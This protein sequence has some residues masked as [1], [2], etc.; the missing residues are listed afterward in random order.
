MVEAMIVF[1]PTAM[2]TSAALSA[3]VATLRHRMLNVSDTAQYD[4]RFVGVA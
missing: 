2:R 3:T 1:A 4:C